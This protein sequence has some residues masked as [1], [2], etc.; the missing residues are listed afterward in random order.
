MRV[1]CYLSLFCNY[2][3]T[4]FE[5]PR[6]IFL[7]TF[8]NTANTA[9]STTSTTASSSNSTLLYFNKL[10]ERHLSIYY[11]EMSNI[12]TRYLGYVLD[13]LNSHDPRF[14]LES[15]DEVLLLLLL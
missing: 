1:S 12:I 11:S 9:N 10:K 5:T 3:T 15:P 2:S 14:V 6:N 8:N 7:S 13:L 4:F